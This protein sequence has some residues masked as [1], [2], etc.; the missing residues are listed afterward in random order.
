MEIKVGN[1][2]K[3]K[4]GNMII[5]ILQINNAS[6]RPWA[7]IKSNRYHIAGC[8]DSSCKYYR[9]CSKN[10]NIACE[11]VSSIKTY[12]KPVSKIEVALRAPYL[13]K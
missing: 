2:Y 13:L 3:E 1:L 8:S 6:T 9:I 10:K 11:Y 5:K 7:L 12:Y 4:E